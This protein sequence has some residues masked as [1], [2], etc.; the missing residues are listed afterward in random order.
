MEGAPPP[1][2]AREGADLESYVAIHQGVIFGALTLLT[3]SIWAKIS[4]GVWWVWSE[5]QL[6]LFLV[7]FLFYCAYFMLRFSVE[8]GPGALLSAGG[9]AAR[10]APLLNPELAA[11]AD[12]F[13]P[14][15]YE[16]SRA[17][18]R[19]ACAALARRE[20]ARCLQH[21]VAYPHP[22]P[23]APRQAT[24]DTD[25]AIDIAYV[26]RGQERLLIL[27]SGL[28][29]SEAFA[30]A[31]VQ[32]LTFERHLTGLLDAGYDVL[33]IHAA[34]PWGFRHR[35]RVDGNNVDLN[36]NFPAVLPR[37][38]PAY[39]AL[40]HLTEPD[41]PV[42]SVTGDS[43][44][45]AVRTGL[46][47]ARHGFDFGF[48]SNGT[49]GGQWSD[50]RGFEYGGADASQQV[51]FWRDVV[52]P[53]MA[54]HRGQIVFLDLHTGL[55]PANTL[56][57]YSGQGWPAARRAALAAFARGWE[58]A[59]I[60]VQAPEESEYQTIGDVIDYVPRLVD[61][62]R[63]VAVTMEWGTIGDSIP[64]YLATNARMILEHQARFRGC[65]SAE[66]CAAV[67][68]NLAELFNPP[69]PAFRASVLSQ[70]DAVL[71]RLAERGL[72]AVAE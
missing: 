66:T 29:G 12:A 51:R 63:V 58:G 16:T 27:Q 49:H 62:D 44:N 11:R 39:D 31:A 13:F 36:R 52:A 15:S 28:H 46:A 48:I 37:Q 30:G 23:A 26:T 56:T 71:G 22:P 61:D 21:P 42:R 25:L 55:G 3:G 8:P 9:C 67:E 4:W 53:L 32:A 40:R 24:R 17:R 18:F 38:N 14:D 41:G 33:M 60:R 20:Q 68:R 2:E 70:A 35:R 34:N 7:L 47:F 57:I 43:F 59:G 65:V 1:L 50:P 69:A 54:L 19:A 64:D 72:A 45:L 6:V 10:P 5:N